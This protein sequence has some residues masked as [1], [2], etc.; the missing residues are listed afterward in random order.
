M[1]ETAGK[2]APEGSPFSRFAHGVGGG[3][4][5]V[6]LRD[7]GGGLGGSS[8]RWREL[9]KTAIPWAQQSLLCD[10]SLWSPILPSYSRQPQWGAGCRVWGAL[11]A[12]ACHPFLFPWVLSPL[13]P[14]LFSQVLEITFGD[15][16]N[17]HTTTPE[18][19]HRSPSTVHS[20]QTFVANSC[21]EILHSCRS[22]WTTVM[23]RG[24]EC[25]C[26]M[27]GVE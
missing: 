4:S 1:D 8:S 20:A 3:A 12:T 25:L 15:Q 22:G 9:E 6:L 7:K 27:M 14:S 16:T 5:A 10:S 13:H 19:L 24:N 18:L 26:M 11:G 2:R 17:E 21:D 23:L